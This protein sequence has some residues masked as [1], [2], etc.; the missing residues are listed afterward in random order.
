[1]VWSKMK[2]GEE[3]N[4]VSRFLQSKTSIPKP[5]RKNRPGKF[6]SSGSVVIQF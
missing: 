4:Y 3:E 2:I 6:V 5:R 1:M